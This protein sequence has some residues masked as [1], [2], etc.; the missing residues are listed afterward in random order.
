MQPADFDFDLPDDRIAL[1]PVNPRDSA[2]LL[3]V[4]PEAPLQDLTVHD[5]PGLLRAGDVLV[6]NDTRV[7]RRG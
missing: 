7:I 1:R 5:L 6:L 3:L 2:R 4:A